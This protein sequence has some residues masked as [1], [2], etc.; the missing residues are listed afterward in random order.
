[1]VPR[2][3]SNSEMVVRFELLSEPVDEGSESFVEQTGSFGGVGF[4]SRVDGGEGFG[5]A[6][7][8][9]G[10]ESGLRC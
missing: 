4:G 6:R 8:E 2:S 1:M 3:P 9:E 10:E 5:D 7:W